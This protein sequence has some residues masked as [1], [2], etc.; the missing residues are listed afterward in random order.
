[1]RVKKV[2]LAGVVL[3]FFG[4]A[5]LAGCTGEA[6]MPAAG[7]ASSTVPAGPVPGSPPPAADPA[8]RAAA[9]PAA[10]L[11]YEKFSARLFKDSWQLLAPGAKREIPLRVWQ[12]VHRACQPVPALR[13]PVIKA[14]TVFG[15]AA[16]VTAVAA[17]ASSRRHTTRE[18]FNFVGGRWGYQP[19]DIGIYFHGSIA[20]DTAAARRAGL[21][22][23]WKIF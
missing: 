22:A 8:V 13:P 7:R 5:C 19:A 21:C 6:G 12:G 3:A 20:A 2:Y 23:G 15:N 9:R 18:V 1:M 17:D 11:F 4:F 10:T 16:I 14:V